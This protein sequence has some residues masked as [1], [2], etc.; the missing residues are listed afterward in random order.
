M[1]TSNDAD[2][3]GPQLAQLIQ[4]LT[5][6]LDTIQSG[7]AAQAQR[8][9]EMEV[10]Q[11]RERE[12]NQAHIKALQET[13]ASLQATPAAT[14][15][16]PTSPAP[17]IVDITPPSPPGQTKKKMTLPDPPRFDGN[18]KKYRN[19]RLEMEGKLR[20]DGCLLGS[21]AD[22]FTYI[23]SRLGDT[24]QS[25]VAAFYE[26]GGPGG[27][28]NP[29]SFLHYLTIT[30]EDPNT[31]QH[32]LSNLD[33]IAQ[34]K[35][36]SFAAF[37]PR[38]EKQLAD[39]GGA[40]WHDVVQINYL[41]KALNDEMKDL[42]VPMVHLPKD[43]PGFVRELHSLGANVDARKAAQRRTG[44]RTPF[45]LPTKNTSPDQKA[46]KH[47]TTTPPYDTM[48]WE[49]TKVSRMVQRDNPKLAGKRAKWIDE[50]EKERRRKEGR[51]FR[52]GRTGCTVAECP[53]LPAKPPPV[54]T[55]VNHTRVKRSKPVIKA[56]VEDTE[57][58]GNT[59]SDQ[60]ETDE[61]ELKE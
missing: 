23:Y 42:L 22:Q 54:L 16:S 61:E 3:N 15:R 46:T 13:I 12:A 37:Y 39:A 30:Y 28:R 14:P 24:P 1:P 56:L 29:A 7:Q 27:T 57:D 51:C 34:G 50:R 5:A 6:Q 10:Y 53:L 36:E 17:P 45:S 49:P 52:C 8:L 2:E 41:Q 55:G 38:F 4:L 26:S 58:E 35:T 44:R 20:T 43:Y 60:T 48:D 18:R 40:T 59:P 47:H 19:W 9:A 33:S 25:T 31:A 21:P 11:A 32:A